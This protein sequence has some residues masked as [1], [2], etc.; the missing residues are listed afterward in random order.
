MRRKKNKLKKKKKFNKNNNNNKK[1]L[2]LD[3][4]E[5]WLT[6]RFLKLH[7]ISLDW[8]VYTCKIVLLKCKRVIYWQTTWI[9][10]EKTNAFEFC[11]FLFFCFGVFSLNQMWIL[12]D[13]VINKWINLFLKNWK[14][15]LWWLWLLSSH[16]Y[17]TGMHMATGNRA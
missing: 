10:R 15:L 2:W 5:S 17:C 3:A 9:I 11:L 6:C 7:A 4:F 14:W 16:I 8:C 12:L 13:T 1:M